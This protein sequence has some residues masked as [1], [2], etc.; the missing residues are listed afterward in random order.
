MSMSYSFSKQ[1]VSYHLNFK[2]YFEKYIFWIIYILKAED[3]LNYED[4][5]H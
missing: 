5:V 1:F 4:K 3:D 2:R